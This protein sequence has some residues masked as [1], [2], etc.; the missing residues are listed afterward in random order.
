MNN[1]NFVD[2]ETFIFD[3]KGKIN[4]EIKEIYYVK[5]L[6]EYFKIFRTSYLYK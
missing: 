6:F 5:L 1:T 3:K 4:E 2:W